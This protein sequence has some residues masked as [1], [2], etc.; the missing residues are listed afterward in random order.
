[1][2]FTFQLKMMVLRLLHMP[3]A[4][5][6]EVPKASTVSQTNLPENARSA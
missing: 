3:P 6:A 4:A 5:A 2:K 1:V